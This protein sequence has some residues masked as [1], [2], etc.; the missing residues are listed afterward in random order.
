MKECALSWGTWGLLGRLA[1]GGQCQSHPWTICRP[2]V[3]ES[4]KGLH[5]QGDTMPGLPSR[6]TCALDAM[7]WVSC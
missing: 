6:V 7:P 3:C 1:A 2:W 5:L 4:L